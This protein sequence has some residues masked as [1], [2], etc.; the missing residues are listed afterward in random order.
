[1]GWGSGRLGGGGF[2]QLEGLMIEIVSVGDENRDENDDD[3]DDDVELT[4]KKKH[5]CRQ[6]V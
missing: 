2:R 1:V 6:W 3:D 4:C 5:A